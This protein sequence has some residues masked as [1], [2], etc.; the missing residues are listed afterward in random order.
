[1][2]YTI[3]EQKGPAL[4]GPKCF[5][6]DV[7]ESQ[8]ETL[9]E[10]ERLAVLAR[11]ISTALI[12]GETLE[13]M[14]QSCAEVLVQRLDA[15]FA[16]IWTLNPDTK[17]LELRA[18]AGT[19][20]HLD[21]L[22]SRVPLGQFLIGVI[23]QERQPHLTNQVIGDPRVGNQEWA[24][25]NGMVAFAGYPLIV[26][27]QVI[28][29]VAMFARKE[30]TEAVLQSLGVIANGL[31]LGIA[32]KR[33]EEERRRLLHE[34]VTLNG[35]G[36][37]IASNLDLE[38]L[39]QAVTDAATDLTGAQFGVFC[40]NAVDT[41]GV[42][43]MLYTLTGVPRDQFE[44]FPMP[45]ARDLFGPNFC[46][47]GAVRIGDVKTDTRYGKNSPFF[48]LPPGRLPVRSFLSVPVVSRSGEAL[49]GLFFGHSELNVFRSQHERILVVMAAQAAI[50]MDNARLADL[51]ERQRTELAQTNAYIV[52]ILESVSDGFF[53]VDPAW[54]Y[55]FVNQR[56][57][58]TARKSKEEMLGQSIWEVF[59][60]LKDTPLYPELKRAMDER[61]HVHFEYTPPESTMCIEVE[62]Y[63]TKDGL[64]VL[65]RDVTERRHF[66]EKMRQSQKLESLGVLAGGVAHDFNNLLTGILGNASLAL[67]TVAADSTIHGML[68]DVVSASE[69]A[70]HLTKQLL[71]YAGKG[72]FVIDHIDLSNMVR[73]ISHLIQSSIPKNVRVRLDLA[74]K[75]PCIEADAAQI[76]QIVM[77]LVINGAEAIPA[78]EM[79]NVL[80][81][82]RMQEVDEA[83]I[84]LT[85][86]PGE[87]A[88]G[89]YV[90]LEIHDTGIGMDDAT[91]A[92]IFDPFFT[93]K[94]T[95]RGL[96]LAAVMG[97]VRGHKGA[98][99]VYTAPK[100]GSTFKVLFPCAAGAET[101]G[102]TNR[103]GVALPP[104]R[105]GTILV[106]DDEDIV[107]RTAKTTLERSGYDV[108]VA[109][110]G[111]EGVEMFRA[112]SNKLSL[113]LLDLT[114]PDMDGEEVLRRLKAIRSEVKVVLSSGFN[115]T[116]V[117]QRFTGK[118][119]AGFIQK[120]YTAA[121]LMLKVKGS[122]NSDRTLVAA[123]PAI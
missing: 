52:N 77:N 79:G 68:A 106:I 107:R 4:S 22:D 39:A 38:T 123:A 19:S 13:Q 42:P 100:R 81:T 34:A 91:V 75:L 44:R 119:L 57:S 103:G 1:M 88:P 18:S 73:E 111:H 70:A 59:P 15:A 89:E 80:V 36:R 61:R 83:Y 49:G 118:G 8:L 102:K 9:I 60:A 40:Y 69:R 116:E 35:L 45:S 6:D 16:R 94:F 113:V 3:E 58:E 98:L 26:E 96:G 66:D 48:G 32:R 122:I 47:D 54:R 90:A 63:P 86:S 20:T 93:T 43:Q 29:V 92:R 33:V 23:A 27:A 71:A 10:R 46:G 105:L 7:S 120:P 108:V 99:R 121:A 78:N 76:Q 72:R 74:E 110:N 115:E 85:F 117:I 82:T 11:H 95:G 51:A 12:Q 67:D 50:A 65:S 87:I 37:L 17:I 97:I 112:L 25:E 62:A 14:L 2:E 41:R 114:M 104:G 5:V 24:K 55:R 21:G 28:G 56:A 64:A 30:L 101:A 31:A 84:A 53:S 109:E